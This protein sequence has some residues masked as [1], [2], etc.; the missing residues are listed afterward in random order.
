PGQTQR[1]SLQSELQVLLLSLEGE[2]LPRGES[3]D[4]R[5]DPAH[6]HPPV[7]G[8][9]AGTG[10]PCGMAGWGADAAGPGFLSQRRAIR[11]RV[12]PTGPEGDS[13]DSDQRHAD[14]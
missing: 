3:P 7:D 6:L 12:S 4:G 9:L 5:G 1:R 13:Y 2:P 14:R 8:V 10:G 11:R